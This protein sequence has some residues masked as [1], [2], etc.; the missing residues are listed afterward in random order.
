M[1][2]AEFF[3][4][5]GGIPAPEGSDV[6][7]GSWTCPCGKYG[8]N[9]LKGTPCGTMWVQCPSCGRTAEIVPLPEDPGD[10]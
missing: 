3:I 7:V 1:A 9:D 4:Q 2:D 5:E 6:A 10:A 8:V